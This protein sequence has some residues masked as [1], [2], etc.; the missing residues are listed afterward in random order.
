MTAVTEGTG[1]PDYKKAAAEARADRADMAGSKAAAELAASGALDG[2]FAKIDSGEV[3]LTGDGGFIPG[4]IKATLERGLQ[5]ELTSHLGYEK[6]APEASAVANS[7]NGTTPKTVATQ[8]GEVDLVTPRD[9]DGT[10]TPVLVPKGSRRL[11]GLDEMII[12]LYA[13]GM[14]VRDIAHHLES[15]IGTELSH[16]TISNITDAVSEEILE[17]QTRPLEAFYPVVYLDAIVV[18]VRDGA[19][20]VNKSAHIAVG[21][22]MDGIKHVLGIWIQTSEGAKFW[23]GV[24]A[25]LAN[26]GVRDVLIV[27]CDGLTGLPEAIEATWQHATVQT[28]VVHLIRASMRFVNYKDRKAVAKALRAIYTA[29]NDKTAKEAFADFANANWGKQYPHAVATWEAAW[30][31]FIP[32]LAFPPELRRVIYTT[33]SIESLNYQLGKVTKNRGHFPSDEAVV[34][35]LWLAICNIEDKRA[36][37]RARERGKPSAEPKASGRLVEGQVVTNWKQALGQ[38]AIAYPDRINP[39]L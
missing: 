7:R 27:C 3:E 21:V 26:R 11:S 16:E 31:R 25:E 28:C 9:R 14:T 38:L 12:S 18:K 19:H 4:L 10:F 23:A 22:D 15:T 8:T 24:C 29:S 37:E 39:Y 2:L 36:R 20:V 30:E 5:A 34:K 1:R 17:W 33:N 6:G 13:G 32:F 35:L